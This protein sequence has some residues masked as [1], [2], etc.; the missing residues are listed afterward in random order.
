MADV[1]W[2]VLP[3]TAW[4]FSNINLRI[5]SISVKVTIDSVQRPGCSLNYALH[6]YNGGRRG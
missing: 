3:R 6:L 5:D 2:L 4:F 1:R